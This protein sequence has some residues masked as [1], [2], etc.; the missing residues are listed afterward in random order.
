MPHLASQNTA[1]LLDL[2][3]RFADGRR[4][5]YIM[6]PLVKRFTAEDK[7]ALV[8]YYSVR[9]RRCEYKRPDDPAMVVRGRGLYEK[10]C[11]RCHG[12]RGRGKEGYSYIAGQPEKYV[13]RSLT[14]FREKS[15]GGVN[16]LM[17]AA[18][19]TTVE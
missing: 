7:I 19:S 4:H 6:S 17:A 12:P 10:R 2:I 11:T 3:E 15:G 18:A 8:L 5:D 13:S 1:Y 9:T 14:Y 16:A